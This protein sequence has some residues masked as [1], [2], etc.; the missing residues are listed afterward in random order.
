MSL[1]LFSNSTMAS[2]SFLSHARTWLDTQVQTAGR[3]A[4]FVPYAA[5]S[6]DR[7]SRDAFD[8][9][10]RR[11]GEVFRAFGCTV[12]SVHE[13]DDPYTAVRDAAHVIVGGGNSFLLLH[14]LQESGLL[15]E[16]QQVV[17]AGASY[18]GWSAGAILAG[19]TI[20]TTNDMPVVW[21]ESPDACS[22]VPFHINPHYIAESPAGYG[23]E[24]R[25]DRLNE[26]LKLHPESPVIAMPEGTG[27][28]VAAK[29]L[30]IL[31]ATGLPCFS[32]ADSQRSFGAL[33][34]SRR[35]FA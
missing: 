8:V 23:G 29:R 22:F 4:V 16:I 15:S 14:R 32:A 26:F 34:L 27:I 2:R 3:E 17:R 1:L 19:P 9:Y 6:A 10:A 5:V 25:P 21:P 18:T 35:F 33:E 24:T 12:R 11:V 13:V 7:H 28:V 20:G 30:E 31:G